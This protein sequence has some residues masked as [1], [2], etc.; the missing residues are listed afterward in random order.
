[1]KEADEAIRITDRKERANLI[2]RTLSEYNGTENYYPASLSRLRYTDGIKKM[3]DLCGAHWLIDA[4]A[5][6][7]KDAVKHPMLAD[8]QIWRVTLNKGWSCDL[9]CH[10]DWDDEDPDQFPPIIHQHIQWTDFPLDGFRAY[11]SHGTLYLPS[12]H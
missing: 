2:E 3:A 9:T 6:H 12:E 10:A 1:M 5:S 7:Q 11:V 8:F 4:I